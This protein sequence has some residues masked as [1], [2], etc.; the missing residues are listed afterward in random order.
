MARKLLGFFS[1][2]LLIMTINPIN[3]MANLMGNLLAI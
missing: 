2:G 3:I 1:S